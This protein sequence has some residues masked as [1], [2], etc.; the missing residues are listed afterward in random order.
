MQKLSPTTRA[1]QRRGVSVH[2]EIE[3]DLAMARD[4]PIG[5]NPIP[6]VNFARGETMF[7]VGALAI[8]VP[9]PRFVRSVPVLCHFN[10]R[11]SILKL[12]ECH[13]KGG[14][15]C[16]NS[17]RPFCVRFGAAPHRCCGTQLLARLP[18]HIYIYIYI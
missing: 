6:Y 13:R 17:I 15:D 14:S 9:V 1:S 18:H 5:S 2:K 7:R 3:R 10:R 4:K 16:P 8:Y 11:Y 12:N